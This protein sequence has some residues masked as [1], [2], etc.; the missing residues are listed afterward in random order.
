MVGHYGV[1]IL[2]KNMVTTGTDFFT[3][4]SNGQ[5]LIFDTWIKQCC[6]EQVAQG[7]FRYIVLCVDKRFVCFYSSIF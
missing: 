4:Q 3:G 7:D 6:Y 5:L 1:P 2:R